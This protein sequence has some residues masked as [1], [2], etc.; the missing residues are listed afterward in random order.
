MGG[1]KML[2]SMH[3]HM[4]WIM[5]GIVV[6]ITV[7]FLFFGIYPSDIGGRSVAKVGGEVISAEE[8]NR[9]YRGM[10]E[11]YRKLLKDQFND[12][13]AKSLKSQALQEL[14]VS[15]LFVQ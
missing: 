5:W 4:K 9:V 1:S 11:N 3:R 12:A 7:T 6:L 2:E 10:T 13:F 14:I 15:K 8:F